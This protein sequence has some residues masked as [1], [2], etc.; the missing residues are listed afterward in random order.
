[1]EKLD[2]KNLK[3]NF[4][5]FKFLGIGTLGICF[6][7]PDEK[8]L[9]IFLNKYRIARLK[10]FH[11]D[12]VEHFSDINSLGNDTYMVPEKLLMRGNEVMGYLAAFGKGHR[13]SN[14]SGNLRVREIISAYDVLME[15]TQ[16]ISEQ[17]FRLSDV[18]NGNIL[19][20]EEL[21]HFS[22]IDLDK[23]SIEGES[24]TSDAIMRM[25]MRAINDCIICSLFG[26][27]I[28]Y[29]TINFY[30]YDLQK[31]YE[32]VTLRD[33]SAIDDF[34]A[35]LFEV[36]RENDPTISMLHREKRK[37]LSVN[38]IEDYYNRLF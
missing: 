19:Y 18:H 1:M 20:D 16:K 36:T 25:N 26:V 7:T 24:L 31:L 8:V 29:K 30:D 17:K 33:Y 13:I 12:L 6:L 15:D 4:W 27:N 9:K 21:N 14:F 32:E 11:P 5:K 34:F 23:G 35:Y 38:P 3:I 28:L 10:E 2:V 37:I 22:C